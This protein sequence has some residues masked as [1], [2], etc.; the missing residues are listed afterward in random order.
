MS[1]ISVGKTPKNTSLMEWLVDICTP[2]MIY[3]YVC[4]YTYIYICIIYTNMYLHSLYDYMYI[5]PGT[6]TATTGLFTS[7]WPWYRQIYHY[8][9]QCSLFHCWGSPVQKPVWHGQPCIKES[10][11]WFLV[12]SQT[13]HGKRRGRHDVYLTGSKHV[14]ISTRQTRQFRYFGSVIIFRQIDHVI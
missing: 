7:T 11:K 2:R 1:L 3:R 9:C 5:G 6:R 12:L 10:I 13:S 8:K 14:K 4:M